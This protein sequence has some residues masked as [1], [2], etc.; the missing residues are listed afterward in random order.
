MG[1]PYGD[2]LYGKGLYSRRPDWW[3]K[4]E[5]INDQWARQTCDVSVWSQIDRADAPW[6]QRQRGKPIAGGVNGKR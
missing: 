4:K 6:T 3:R 1:F 5:C 2:G